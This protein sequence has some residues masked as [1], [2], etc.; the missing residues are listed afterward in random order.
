MPRPHVKI[1]T[2]E[3]PSDTTLHVDGKPVAG[4]VAFKVEQLSPDESARVTLVLDP[5]QVDIDGHLLVDRTLRT[6]APVPD[7]PAAPGQDAGSPAG[8]PAAQ[9]GGT[10]G[11]T[12]DLSGKLSEALGDAAV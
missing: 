4:C 2:G 3:L 5:E 6:P 1:T 8:A 9:A 11:E 7:G 12:L 10:A